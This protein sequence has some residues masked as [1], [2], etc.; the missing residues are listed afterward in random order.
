MYGYI[1]ETTNIKTGDKY[2]GKRY[3]VAFDKDYLGETENNKLAIAIEK[4][5]RPSFEARMLMPYES[6]DALDYAFAEMNVEPASKKE[7]TKVE[8]VPDKVPEEKPVKRKSKKKAAEEEKSNEPLS[9]LV[10]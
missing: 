3:A 7:A 4:Y 9:E 8:E 2:L 10:E 5:G 6:Q 1:F